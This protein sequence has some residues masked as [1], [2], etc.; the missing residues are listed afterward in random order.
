MP[1]DSMDNFWLVIAVNYGIPGVLFMIGGFLSVCFGLGR[2]RD[3][4]FQAAQCRKG[5]IISLCGV[6]AAG[7][8]VHFWNATYVLFIFLLGSGMWMFERRN[9]MAAATTS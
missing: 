8:T 3:L 1:A 2:L 9:R 4:P 5:L 7:C 6:A